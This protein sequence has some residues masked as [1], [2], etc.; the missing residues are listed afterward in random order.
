VEALLPVSELDA[1]EEPTKIGDVLN[2]QVPPLFLMR[3]V[4]L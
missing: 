4:P 2:L 1:N 3:K